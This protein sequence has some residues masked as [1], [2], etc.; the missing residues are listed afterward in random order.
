MCEGFRLQSSPEWEHFLSPRGQTNDCGPRDACLSSKHATLP[1]AAQSLSYHCIYFPQPPTATKII[2]LGK[3]WSRQA[4]LLFLYKKKKKKGVPGRLRARCC[5]RSKALAHLLAFYPLSVEVGFQF[6]ALVTLHS[7]AVTGFLLF[8]SS[9]SNGCCGG[10][11]RLLIEASYQTARFS[12]EPSKSSLGVTR[13]ARPE[14][15]VFYLNSPLR[16]NKHVFCKSKLR[17]H[18]IGS[19]RG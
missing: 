10:E 19:E 12:P 7:R 4:R 9:Y 14:W 17:E 1:H 11:E 2:Y 16:S 15:A 5:T 6:G 8:T 3:L 18:R 13:A